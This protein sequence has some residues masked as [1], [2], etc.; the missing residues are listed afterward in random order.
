VGLQVPD[1]KK[2]RFNDHQDKQMLGIIGGSGLY[3]L[4]SVGQ[5]KRTRVKTAYDERTVP[6][7]IIVHEGGQFVFLPRHGKNHHI[8]PHE[9]NY[10]ANLAAL[11]KLGVSQIV[12]VNA[13]GGITENTKPGAIVVPDQLIDYTWGRA[14]TYAEGEGAAVSHIDFTYPF[15]EALSQRLLNALESANTN[16]SQRRVVLEQ[17]VYGVTQ[18]PRLETAAEIKRMQKDGCD[19]VGMTAMPEAALARELGIDY[20]M[21]ALSVNRAAGILPDVI[22]MEEIQAVMRDGQS[23]LHGVL[24]RLIKE[25][26]R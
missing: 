21:L 12:A 7:E 10:R 14:S 8:A 22:S 18:G 2:G 23:F 24:L 6:A 11:H 20:A 5:V 9:I 1:R 3:S 17:A 26:A 19:I 13:V 4:E 25:G 15:D 16:A